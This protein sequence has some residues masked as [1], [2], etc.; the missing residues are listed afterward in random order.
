MGAID[1]EAYIPIDN[2]VKSIPQA[3]RKV[4]QRQDD[5]DYGHQRWGSA[6]IT[7]TL[8]PMA[9]DEVRNQP[10]GTWD[11]IPKYEV[12]VIPILKSEKVSE[13]D[14]S[15]MV[16]APTKQDAM[17]IAEQKFRSS[18]PTMTTTAV[19]QRA[20]LDPTSVVVN[21]EK[22]PQQGFKWD[23]P[24]IYYGIQGLPVSTQA[25]LKAF[26]S[27][28]FET[29]SEAQKALKQ[30]MKENSLILKSIVDQ[31]IKNDYRE[32]NKKVEPTITANLISLNNSY[33]VEVKQKKGGKWEV[34]VRTTKYKVNPKDIV[35]YLFMGTLPDY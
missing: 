5:Y 16:E 28:V 1:A 29:K 19:A 18:S 21:L 24:F 7:R 11:N 30:V 9:L 14:H 12:W 32:P 31:Y 27:T 4:I 15:I 20:Q 8:S 34:T 26:L 6:Q 17:V 10:Q 25:S 35:G 3:W 22:I 2:E 23:I 33:T 13:V